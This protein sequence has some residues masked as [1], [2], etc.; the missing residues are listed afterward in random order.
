MFVT[1][2][3]SVGGLSQVHYMLLALKVEDCQICSQTFQLP[4]IGYELS[5]CS[6]LVVLVELCSINKP[7]NLSYL[8]KETK[9]SEA[10]FMVKCFHNVGIFSIVAYK[11]QLSKRKTE[12]QQLGRINIKYFYVSDT[13]FSILVTTKQF[14]MR[15][16]KEDL[17]S[18]LSLT[19]S[20][21]HCF[22]DRHHSASRKFYFPCTHKLIKYEPVFKEK[23]ELRRGCI[24][25]HWKDLKCLAIESAQFNVPMK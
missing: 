3:L 17:L 19:Q 18:S 22:Q 20:L 6:I 8:Y 14:L 21:S 1:K 16:A 24:N 4:A 7:F 2:M 5:V 9:N 25:M 15:I 10:V 12:R 11:V 13:I 23:S